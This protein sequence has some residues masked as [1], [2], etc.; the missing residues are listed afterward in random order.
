MILTEFY[1]VLFITFASLKETQIWG[2]S[3]LQNKTS[4]HC[5]Q[6]PWTAAYQSLSVLERGVICDNLSVI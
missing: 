1:G 3:E 4:L 5:N 6:F 2:E